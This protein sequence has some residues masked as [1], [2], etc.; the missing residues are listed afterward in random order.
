VPDLAESVL[1]AAGIGG[2]ELDVT[3]GQLSWTRRTFLIHELDPNE[4][5]SVE[6][7]I[8]FYPP[9]ARPIVEAGIA[10]AIRDGTP[11]DLE[12][13]FVTARG[14]RIW[15]RARGRA[16]REGG[17]TTKLYGSFEDVTERRELQAREAR[18]SLV[19]EQMTNVI[20]IVGRDRR[21]EWVNAAFT[22]LTGFT[23]DEMKGRLPSERLNGPDTD[24]AATRR[25]AESV[26]AGVAYTVEIL[27]YAKDGRP[28][29]MSVTGTPMRDASGEVIGFISVETDI[30][31]Q[32][33]LAAREARLSL[34]ARQMSNVVLMLD[35]Q[36]R[37]EWV[38]DA[39]TRVT[40]WTM[41]DIGGRWPGELLAGPET[42]MATV[43]HIA[44]C[45]RDGV[46]FE[47]ELLNYSKD[48]GARLKA[49]VGTPIRDAAGAVTGFVCVE[50]DITERREA[51]EQARVEA[52]ERERAE[53]LLRD[54][55]DTIP[56][57]VIAYDRDER[58][59]LA[60]QAHAAIGPITGRVVR[61]G[62]R[63][64]D[65]VRLSTEHGQFA[66]APTEPAARAA[67]IADLLAS[68]RAATGAP[69]VMR[70]AD[71]RITQVHERRSPTGNL[72]IVRHDVT[73]LHTAEATARREAEER[74]RAEAL[75]RDV[76]DTLPNAVTAYDADDRF[77]LANRAYTE[78]FPIS[79]RFAVPGRTH[80]E[81]IRMAM[82]EGQYAE[83]PSDPAE[84]E[85][86]VARIL[87]DF[88]A[89]APHTLRLADG[90]II[91]V[92]ARRSETGTTVSV[93][94][95]TTE[96]HA[97]RD[98]ARREAAERARAEALMR[99]VL[100]TLRPAITAYDADGQFILA[101]RAYAEMMPIAARFATPG[102]RQEEV[103]RLA[104][105]H[106]Q[107]G[108]APKDPAEFEA[109]LADRL[110]AFRAGVKRDIRLPDGRVME[111]LVRRSESGT[112][113]TVRTDTTELYAA[114][115]K[116]RQEAEER[117]R[118]EALLRDVLDTLPNAVTAYDAND[119]FILAN[120]MANELFPIT[121]RFAAPGRSRVD[122]LRMAAES[123]QYA[124]A[125]ADPTEREAWLR[126]RLDGVHD[127]APRTIRLTDGR[128][129]QIRE[130]RSDTGTL[131]SVRTDITELTRAQALLR[132]VLDTL[133]NA[134]TAYDADERF[135]MA[136][137]VYAELFPITA[138]F[139]VPGRRHEDV[140]RMAADAG[141]YAD[142]PSDPDEREAWIAD[143]LRQFRSGVPRTL[144]L[145]EGR[146]MQV[147]EGR[148]ET[149]IM[150]TVRTDTTDLHLAEEKARQEAAERERAQALLRDVLDTLPHAVIAYD[151]D[152]RVILTNQAFTELFPI[153]AR[154]THPGA[155]MEQVLRGAAAEGQYADAPAAAEA[156]ETWLAGALDILRSGVLW[157]LKL[158]D[159]RF[160]QSRGR[161]S[162]SGTLV[163][164]RTDVTELTRA[165]ALLRDV[166]EALPSAVIAYDR[167][168]RMVL[169]N[170]AAAEL[171]PIAARFVAV[172]R[173][174]EEVVRLSAENGQYLDVGA[175]P[176]ARERWI[177][178]QLSL[179]RA[180]GEARTVR[181]ADGR[182][183]Q[184]R[185]RRSESGYLVC[186]RT[187]T[188]ELVRAQALLQDVLDAL[189]SA[190]TA[191]DPDE[192]LILSNR[193]YADLFP[194]AARFA[195]LG[196]RLEDT[197]RLAIEHG[198][199]PDAGMTREE[200]AAWLESRLLAHR[201]P[202]PARTMRLPDGRYVQARESRSTTGVTVSI[203]TDTTDL[204][205]AEQAMRQQAERDP[206]TL[207]ANR[208]AFLGALERALAHGS[209]GR[210]GGG[211][212][213]LLDIDYFKQIN[214]TLGHDVGDALLV[215]IAAR[216]RTHLRGSDLAA[217]LGGDEYGVV[218]PGLTNAHTLAAR[219]DEIHASLSA[220]VELAGRLMRI[221]LSVG[222][223]RFPT[224]GTDAAKLLKNA[225]LALYE[226]K[227]N[228]RGRWSAF[229]PDQAEALEHHTKL[230]DALRG[231]LAQGQI[232]VAL[233]PKRWLREGGGHAGF[234][235]LARWHDGNRWVP[236]TEFIPVAE[237]AGL[238]G[239]LGHKVMEAALARV[240]EIR[241]QG[242]DPG[243]V[244]VNVTSAQLLDS[245]FKDAILALLRCY[246]LRPT[247][248]ELEVTETVLL[249]RAAERIDLVLREFNELGV[250]LAL[251]DFGTGYASLAHLSRLPIDRLKID[252][253]FIDGIGG[254]GAGGVIARTVVSLAHSLG[255]EA[256]AEG[257]ETPE[258]VAF[259]R[260][261][262]CDAAQGY[263]FAKPLTTTDAAVAYL[264][265]VDEPTD[266]GKVDIARVTQ[267]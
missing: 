55:L 240:R 67:W 197:L 130:R 153:A 248:L 54:V 145:A 6:N 149:G 48:G 24:P 199:F 138:R 140:V 20:M 242:L 79:S 112:L 99:D 14:R 101:N 36:G 243:R 127:G 60:N 90:R 118:A 192:R 93:R 223:T 154:F 87:E 95:D 13:P 259:L 244:A 109:W 116:A 91:D 63:L 17:R 64:E 191:Y 53:A 208:P 201:N 131:V 213:L 141:Q 4:Q 175:T 181:L 254:G 8:N 198:Q 218:M 71:G 184:A 39:F 219:M 249:G 188:T 253:S 232:T 222:V 134:V 59:I 5:P 151:S 61:A 186:V 241:D 214:D 237:E 257:V 194:I 46:G 205:R 146:V 89:T 23:L 246:H 123:G 161:R 15:V 147:R 76:L 207:L 113:V 157:N 217:R 44:D 173:T 111:A 139:A 96:F 224:D 77:I 126:A 69:R 167:D 98:E 182:F 85:A 245:H 239:Q 178:E 62:R 179:Y 122:I 52:G 171:M 18:L 119:G 86:F 258:Q 115:E 102:R 38:N 150:V 129:V 136:N 97:A 135:I 144:R 202:G 162:D 121:A 35:R 7:A 177:A 189:P 117:A 229:R 155:S 83:A 163:S 160:M 169:W 212:L 72:V 33:E 170:S 159:G 105:E 25:I 45:V 211:A 37:T 114:E 200:H 193:A 174:L 74:Q 68:I 11:W 43:G 124:D 168:E 34:V 203:R 26:T 125:P 180:G 104:A 251:D 250:T 209:S 22:R 231:A 228:G 42:D 260:A 120:R 75:L 128:V 51:E 81:V 143:Q 166:L 80:E 47:V 216:M 156:F 82:A 210:R 56:V 58:F 261:A 267:H 50:T 158:A 227:R 66:D 238:I 88:R 165:E 187:E 49:I 132:D 57:A 255:M 94:T 10:A 12:V 3:T 183:A 29:W 152:D 110:D 27:N 264:R 265:T 30:T 65:V 206:L 19:A 106:G 100:D 266:G 16:T 233:Q 2:W 92:R 142:L 73:E 176:A 21:V 133:P 195:S 137:R 220:P 9:E 262:G 263:L 226:S 247:D 236:P 84:R 41:A 164:V 256:I 196:A 185:E 230:A 103:M 221:G 32:R 190:V 148:S 1:D 204:A 70:M 107:Y 252:R 31:E 215:E 40:G 108:D 225:D 78:L 28:H 234:E 235:A 172:G